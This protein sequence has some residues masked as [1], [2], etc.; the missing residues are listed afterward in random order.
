MLTVKVCEVTH[1]E[2]AIF[3]WTPVPGSILFHDVWLRYHKTLLD[4][5]SLGDQE[6]HLTKR[7]VTCDSRQ[8]EIQVGMSPTR[9][10]WVTTWTYCGPD[11]P[12][13]EHWLI[14][15]TSV[16]TKT[17][18]QN[19]L[20]PLLRA[21][22]W[23][24]KAITD[25]KTL[26]RCAAA[27]GKVVGEL[28]RSS[29]PRTLRSSALRL[30]LEL[31]NLDQLKNRIRVN[32]GL[33]QEVSRQIPALG[34]LWTSDFGD[35]LTEHLAR[36]GELTRMAEELTTKIK[37]RQAG[38]LPIINALA[39]F[40]S[41]RM[42][43]LKTFESSIIGGIGMFLAASQASSSLGVDA[44]STLGFALVFGLIGLTVPLIIALRSSASHN[45]EVL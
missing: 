9:K 27:Y 14:A 42:S 17:V 39:T 11:L 23:M 4:S 36:H 33:E 43:A 20:A 16:K 22:A 3:R 25:D 6:Q 26:L 19:E 18:A 37:D 24:H 31:A 34:A 38:L 28:E 35:M 45:R 12:D 44:K 32:T 40:D 10:C 21:L 8:E 2:Q 41:A 5:S 15:D 29:S 30:A 7:D 1:D 13:S